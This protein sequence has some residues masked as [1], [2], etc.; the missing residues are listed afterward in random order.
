MT[1][2]RQLKRTAVNHQRTEEYVDQF[3]GLRFEWAWLKSNYNI[4]HLVGDV[5]PELPKGT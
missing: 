4:E 1:F 3:I 5:L 2:K